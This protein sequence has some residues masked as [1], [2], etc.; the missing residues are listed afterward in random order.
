MGGGFPPRPH[1]SCEPS[2]HQLNRPPFLLLRPW[3]CAAKSSPNNSAILH[4]CGKSLNNRQTTKARKRIEADAAWVA[5]RGGLLKHRRADAIFLHVSQLTQAGMV[6]QPRP[7]VPKLPD[8]IRLCDRMWLIGGAAERNPQSPRGWR[9]R[10][11]DG[12]GL[13]IAVALEKAGGDSPRWLRATAPIA[14]RSPRASGPQVAGPGCSGELH[15]KRPA[16]C[17]LP[18]PAAEHFGVADFLSSC[19]LCRKNLHGKDIFMYR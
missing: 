2:I 14:I 16:S 19:F 4:S 18:P 8:P 3:F 12:V 1:V 10:D 7:T 17:R 9:N 13:G 6:H 5:W 15:R 11:P